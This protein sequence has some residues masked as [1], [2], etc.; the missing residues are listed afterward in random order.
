MS[1]NILLSLFR[2][3]L[4]LN[5]L[6]TELKETNGILFPDLSMSWS[7]VANT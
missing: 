6:H 7:Y 1:I 4:N 5:A 3:I 2:F